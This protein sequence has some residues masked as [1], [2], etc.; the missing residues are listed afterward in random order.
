MNINAT[1]WIQWIP[2]AILAWVTAQFIWPVI[3]KAL[4]ERAAKIA[5][6]LAAADRA[7]T[8]LA[9]ANKAV[10]AQ[11]F[12]EGE[13]KKAE[14]ARDEK[15]KAQ[16][17]A[18]EQRNLAL[19]TIRDVLRDVDN[20]MRTDAKLAPVRL[21]IIN[22]MLPR[23]D[24]VR[25]SALKNTIEDERN[26]I[27]IVGFMAQHTLGRRLVE[28][29]DRVRIFGVER[30]RHAEV[31]VLNGLSAH[32]DTNDLKDYARAGRVAERRVFLVHG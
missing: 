13:Q 4:D 5:D 24:A 29:R 16:K 32:A 9:S 17:L 14:A 25:D 18:T 30:E 27:L 21:K 31:I 8:E 6:G 2:F 3:A 15:D 26:T 19:F 7:K 23:L 10:E 20:L 28:K 1:L 12:A 22:A 11:K